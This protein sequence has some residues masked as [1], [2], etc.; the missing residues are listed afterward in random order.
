MSVF[1]SHSRKD[2][3][4]PEFG[5]LLSDLALMRTEHWI[6][7]RLG[8]GQL[9]WDEIL[10]QIRQADVVLVV[11]TEKSLKSEACRREWIYARAVRR[12]LLPV[13]LSE[14]ASW[15]IPDFISESQILDYS[16]RSDPGFGVAS[17]MQLRDAIERMSREA[18]PLPDPLPEQPGVPPS[19]GNAFGPILEKKE[20]TLAEQQQFVQEVRGHLDVEDDEKGVLLGALREFRARP[21]IT[22]RVADE[23]DEIIA[24]LSAQ[25]ADGRPTTPVAPA[26]AVTDGAP[27][28]GLDTPVATD[29]VKHFHAP[30]L[31]VQRLAVDLQSWYAGD[32]YQSQWYRD[33][34]R[35]V[36]QSREGRSWVRWVGAGAALTVVL[37]MNGDELTVEIG[38]AKW[39][40]K[41]AAGGVGMLIL[42]PAAITAAV[43][44]YRQAQLPGRT[45]E[46]IEQVIPTLT[47]AS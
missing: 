2:R 30:G 36:I 6:D 37:S 35:Y 5:L 20:L 23:V 25:A 41:L 16:Q 29:K 9:W 40:D 15:Q 31:D 24:R 38:G 12:P 19:Y 11:L 33:G 8:G 43:G 46:H 4:V 32:S 1:I 27:P 7:D 45:L 17:A 28:G 39:G 26:P 14:V 13:R 42:W 21:D 22:V 44:S 47:T 18:P 3:A 10:S 34:R